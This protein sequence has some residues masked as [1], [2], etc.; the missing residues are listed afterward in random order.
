MTTLDMSVCGGLALALEEERMDR[1]FKLAQARVKP[2]AEA[3]RGLAEA[4]SIW[5]TYADAECKAVSR[6]FEGGSIQGVMTVGCRTVLTRERSHTIW[7]NHL[8]YM[9]STP[10]P[11]P[12]PLVT[13][14]K[15]RA[16]AKAN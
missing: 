2:D 4:Q 11:V 7:A 6:G 10:P 9:D 16:Q 13:V 5:A 12:E 8:Q 15:E 3:L 14:A 1:Y